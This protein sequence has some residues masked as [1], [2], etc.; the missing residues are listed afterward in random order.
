MYSDNAQAWTMCDSLVF[1]CFW[2][3][4]EDFPKH[5]NL[6]VKNYTAAKSYN[7]L[8]LIVNQSAWV[9]KS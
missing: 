3:P 7:A 8:L 6:D 1:T 4:V 2:E 9:I 5:T